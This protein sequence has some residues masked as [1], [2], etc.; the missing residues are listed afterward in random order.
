MADVESI[1]TI[2]D[3]L[4]KEPAAA[5]KK[6]RRAKRQT[7]RR[8]GKNGEKK[9]NSAQWKARSKRHETYGITKHWI[10]QGI[11]AK[12]KNSGQKEGKRR[13]TRRTYRFT[14]DDV[15]HIL[16][17]AADGDPNAKVMFD[18]DGRF[19]FTI[20]RP[21]KTNYESISDYKTDLKFF[22]DVRRKT[23]PRK[24]KAKST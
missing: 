18:G 24:K 2:N 10:K 12:K 7:Y 5:P 17:E 1:G 13:F 4:G 11:G 8:T 22:N 9:Y 14:V 3:L 15:Q 19:K 20:V 23:G 16:K 21:N 6:K